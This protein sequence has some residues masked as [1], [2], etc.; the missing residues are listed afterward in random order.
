MHC[1]ETRFVNITGHFFFFFFFLRRY[2]FKEVLAL[3]TC[4]FHL[5][6]SLMRSFQFVIFILVMSLFTL[7]SHLF[8]GLPSDLFSVGDHSYTFFTMLV[9][10][11]RC[12]CPNQANL[13][14][15]IWFMMFLLPVSL[16]SSSFDLIRHV[17]SFSS[18]GPQILLRTFLSNTL[19]FGF[20][21][22]F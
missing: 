12:T 2:N 21:V 18:V 17:P 4:V 3:S 1:Q 22:F 5:V 20:Y 6:R 7:S 19:S 11:V 14:A 16:F 15:L 8:F 13:C 10:G 9:P